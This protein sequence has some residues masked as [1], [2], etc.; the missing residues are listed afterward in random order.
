MFGTGMFLKHVPSMW[1]AGR[2]SDRK[3][4]QR[5]VKE[6]SLERTE[7]RSER[8]GVGVETAGDAEIPSSGRD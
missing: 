3:H 4:I 7:R 2:H 5:V 1:R 8:S 6:N